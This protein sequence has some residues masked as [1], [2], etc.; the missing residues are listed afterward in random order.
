METRALSTLTRIL[1]APASRAASRRRWPLDA[2][3]QSEAGRGR[4]EQEGAADQTCLGRAQPQIGAETSD[5]G[6][7][8]IGGEVTGG[9]HG[10]QGPRGARARGHG[11]S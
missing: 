3:R 1:G 4:A 6:G 9:E 10:D 7:E 11:R 8:E 2:P 5:D